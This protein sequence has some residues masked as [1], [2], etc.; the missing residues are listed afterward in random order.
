MNL[1]RNISGRLVLIQ[2]DMDHTVYAGGGASAAAKAKVRIHLLKRHGR[3]RSEA[4]YMYIVDAP[5]EQLGVS[6]AIL[7][8]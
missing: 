7:G 6:Q 8:M 1:S 2:K 5:E 4:V 3:W